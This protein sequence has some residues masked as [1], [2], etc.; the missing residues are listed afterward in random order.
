MAILITFGIL[1]YFV[2]GAVFAGLFDDMGL[3]MEF[4]FL[5]PI[6]I[7]IIGIVF[8]CGWISGNVRMWVKYRRENAK[9]K[10]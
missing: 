8:G 9:K 10:E 2:I 5:W 1:L 6:F 7:P 3:E 4:Y